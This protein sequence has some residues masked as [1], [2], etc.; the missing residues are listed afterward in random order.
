MKAAVLKK[1]QTPLVLE[2]LSNR[3]AKPGHVIV[4]LRTASLNRRD[5]WITRGLYPGIQVPAIMGSDGA[6]I[7]LE[8]GPGVSGD[9]LG[10]EVILYPGIHWGDCEEAQS[11]TFQV[12]GMP[13]DG[14]FATQIMASEAALHKKHRHLNW[15]E[16]AALPLAGL[17]A[18]RAVFKQARLQP[19]ENILITG[20]GGGV[21]ALAL[22]FAVHAGGQVW[23]TSSSKEKIEQ[24]I[25]MGAK[26]GSNY[27]SEDWYRS[28]L[29][30]AGA[31]Q[32]IIDGAGGKG[33]GRL[34]EIVA[35]GGRIVNYGATAGYPDKV[36]LFKIFWKQI[37]LQGS[38]MGSP[39]DFQAMHAMVESKAIKPPISGTFALEEVNHALDQMRLG[40]HFGKIVLR[41]G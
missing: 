41:C 38:T 29:D 4:E 5:D 21:A 39:S 13:T 18:W 24:A 31:P 14:T 16:S 7:V 27:H 26:G 12:L 19:G 32:V 11:S 10:Q 9:W 36:D 25:A 8:V 28:V 22:Q 34:I 20:V 37:R 17:T 40:T 15:D 6:G 30:Q 33:Y 2:E 35:P 1:I 3:E 23:V